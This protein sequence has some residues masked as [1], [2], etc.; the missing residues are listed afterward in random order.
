MSNVTTSNI[1]LLTRRGH[2]PARV[3]E[4]EEMQARL[5]AA[6]ADGVRL[7]DIG[8]RLGLTTKQVEGRLR[9]LGVKGT[10][11]RAQQ[12]K[13]KADIIAMTRKGMTAEQVGQALGIT[14]NAV[15][16]HLRRSRG[17]L[18]KS[19]SGE[20][21]VDSKA[22]IDMS[23]VPG[24]VPSDMRRD[25]AELAILEGEHGAAKWA[26]AEKFQRKVRGVK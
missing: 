23:L 7:K 19:R 5:L 2:E 6:V 17:I 1:G 24:W 22:E 14:K 9:R 10:G 16:G 12:A 20:Y 13:L 21:V 3:A 18:S 25:Y 8:P 11:Y 26:R 15:R 4:R